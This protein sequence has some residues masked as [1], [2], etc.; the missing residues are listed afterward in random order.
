M[1]WILPSLNSTFLALIPKGAES[2]TPDKYRPIALCN[3]IYKL[4]S[5]VLANRLKPLLPLLISQEQIGYVEGRQIMD[6]VILSNEVI[7]SLKLLKKPGMILKLDLSK[8]FDKLSWC[9]IQQMLLAFGFNATWARWIMN[10]ISSPSFSILLNGSPSKPFRP[11][12]GIRQRDPLSPFI[13]VL[14]AEGL[15]RLLHSAISSQTLKGISL[16]GLHPLS[17]QQFVDDTM[18]FGHPSSQEA[19][20]FKDLLSLFSEASGTS[21]NAT[22]SHLF[23]FHT[24]AFTQRNIAR[25]LGYSIA[26]LPSK[27]LGTPL[28]DSAIKNASWRTLIDKLESRLSSWT[29]RSLNMASRLILIKTVLQRNFLWGSSGLNRKWALVNWNEVCQPKA[30]GRLGLRDPLQS[31]NTM[32]ARVWWN[33]LSKPHTPWARLWQA[34]YVPGCQWKDLIRICPTTPGSLIWNA[35]KLHSAFIQEHNFW[36]VHSEIEQELNQ[37]KIKQ[38]DQQG[39]LRWGHT[40]KGMFTTKEA[41]H[42]RYTPTQANKDKLWDQV[43]QPGFSYWIL[44]KERNNRVFNNSSKPIDTL[45]LLLQYNLRETLAL[46]QW[47]PADLSE[48]PQEHLILNAWNMDFSSPVQI[49]PCSPASSASP[50]IWSPPAPNSFKLKFDGVTKGNPG[51]VGYGG[52]FRDEMGTIRHIYHGNIGIDTNNAAELEGI[53]KGICIAEQENLYPLEVEGDSFIII[54]AI[55]RI[56]A[57]SPASKPATSWR[58]LSRLEQMEERLRIPR[59]ITFRHIRHTANKVADKMANQ[60]VNQQINNFSSPLS[61]TNDEQLQKECIALAQHD[62]S[63]QAERR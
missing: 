37:R 60:G 21:I 10:L 63:I 4:I 13:F 6:G 27:Y 2:N 20:A 36:E 9:Y 54:A 16:H 42:L 23:V 38:S 33:W 5:K 7:H 32:G 34:K 41:H 1:H 8:A 58:L 12:R 3:I 25:I 11:S 15:N 18:L 31:N 50:L 30:I 61:D 48:L 46:R 43:W 24:P 29:F 59:S 19:S 53:W 22:K 49:N 26:T 51:P 52:V 47:L 35:P 39:K 40:P 44:W 55:I 56:Q 57:G 14:M 17:H 45:W 62:Y 28:L